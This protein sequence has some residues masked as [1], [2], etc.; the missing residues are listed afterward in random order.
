MIA[1]IAEI[2]CAKVNELDHLK[3]TC[4]THALHATLQLYYTD[5]QIQTYVHL[6]QYD[7]AHFL[8]HC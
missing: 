1:I 5:L 7:T 3:N 2:R 6:P 4:L 8:H